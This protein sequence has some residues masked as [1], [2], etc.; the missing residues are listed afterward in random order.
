MFTG[1]QDDL[2]IAIQLSLIGC[3]KFWQESKYKNFRTEDYLIP[4][5][6]S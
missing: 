4:N 6:L 1:K 3:Q 2:C 5:V